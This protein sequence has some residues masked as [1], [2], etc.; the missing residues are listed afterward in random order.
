MSNVLLI[1]LETNP[2]A[3]QMLSTDWSITDVSI[4]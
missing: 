2:L 3:Y 1:L 4:R